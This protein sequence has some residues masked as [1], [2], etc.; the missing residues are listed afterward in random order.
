MPAL[1]DN[2]KV[3]SD[4]EIITAPPV[5]PET[6]KIR[7]AG[8]LL[9]ALVLI[10]AMLATTALP[11]IQAYQVAG[12]EVN[13]HFYVS[14]PHGNHVYDYLR[15]K[16]QIRTQVAPSV[17]SL[18]ITSTPKVGDVYYLGETIS[19]EVALNE[20]VTV[21]SGPELTL[22]MGGVERSAHYQES[23]STTVLTF[24]YVIFVS[25]RDGDG[26]AV[27]AGE[28]RLND[29]TTLSHTGLTNQPDH[30]VA[31]PVVSFV[32]VT[33]RWVVEE[34]KRLRVVLRIDPPVPAVP[35]A[36]AGSYEEDDV[37]GGILIF[38]SLG[39]DPVVDELIAFVFRKGIETRSISYWIPLDEDN[40][41]TEPRTVRVVINPIFPDYQVSQHSE[42]TV[43]VIDEDAVNNPPTGAPTISGRARAGRT[44]TT[45]TGSISDADGLM[46]VAYS[47]Q[48]LR[49]SGSND[50]VIAG[51]TNMSYGVTA[52]DVGSQ[53]KVRVN[54]TD[55]AGN[56]ES[57]TS[58]LTPIITPRPEPT[59]TPRPTPNAY[60]NT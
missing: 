13:T 28:L 49:V 60:S 44:L 21:T 39:D 6:G 56:P 52:T 34:G 41:T 14:N 35:P 25:D 30:K 33:P 43:R 47:Y 38:D 2:C 36:Q 54:F 45:N 10:A 19:V 26:I 46:E 17:T 29:N 51:A 18:A 9:A 7:N 15:S 22:D 32:S 3:P 48:W 8:I 53:L 37:R 11:G 57:L 27:A 20:P 5:I 12:E 31:L 40:L 50:G 23:S 1:Q 59:P 4:N 58:E 55:D 42:I 24:E 16:G